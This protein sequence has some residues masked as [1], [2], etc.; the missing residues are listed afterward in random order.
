MKNI[1]QPITNTQDV[2]DSRDII[3]RLEDLEGTLEG[4]HE[5]YVENGGTLSFEEWLSDETI[6]DCQDEKIEYNML[7]KFADEAKGY[8][9][10][11]QY[12]STLIRDSYFEDYAKELCEDIGDMP[13][14]LPWYIANHIDWEGVAREIQMDYTSIDFDGVKY[15]VR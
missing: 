12:G 7:K 4:A 2:I 9:E 3:E 8:S 15:W 6:E 1:T 13:K 5:G 10:D 11:W 14:E